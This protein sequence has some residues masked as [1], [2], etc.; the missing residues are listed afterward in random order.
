MCKTQI[1]LLLRTQV[2]SLKC[3]QDESDS[4][5]LTTADKSL[6]C[7]DWVC[8]GLS[9]RGV[10]LRRRK[11]ELFQENWRGKKSMIHY[12]SVENKAVKKFF[13]YCGKTLHWTSRTG[14]WFTLFFMRI[15]ECACMQTRIICVFFIVAFPHDFKKC[16]KCLFSFI[17]ANFILK[18][19]K[20]L[21]HVCFL[22]KNVFFFLYK[23]YNLKTTI[24][25]NVWIL[26]KLFRK[27]RKWNSN[28]A[29]MLFSSHLIWDLMLLYLCNFKTA[30]F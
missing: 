10:G 8:C 11:T 23:S 27:S 19:C 4:S 14:L 26:T 12:S 24:V 29:G 13:K 30:H 5:A 6:S 3:Q 1:L 16:S 17:Y 2:S 15:R 22:W 7:S 9:Q 25:Q 18:V 20:R 28:E 21:T